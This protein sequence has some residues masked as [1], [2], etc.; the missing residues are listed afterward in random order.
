MISLTLLGRVLA[1]AAMLAGLGVAAQQLGWSL[2]RLERGASGQ[3]QT[4]STI[5]RR[6]IVYRL[7]PARWTTF[8]F[9]QPVQ[10]ARLI[11][12]PIL[13]AG[14][15]AKGESWVYAVRAELL[16]AQGRVIAVHHVHSRTALLRTDGGRRGPY[17]FYRGSSELVA[18]SDEVR[19]ASPQPFYAI[20]MTSAELAED[21]VAV[22]V[23]LSERRPVLA[24]NAASAFQ[25]YSP[26]DKARLASPNAF[27]PE[28][29]T[30][31]EQSNIAIN[32]W[33]PVG[34]TGIDGRDYRMRIL[35][36]EEGDPDVSDEIRLDPEDGE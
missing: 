30:P 10:Q 31:A 16:D 36:E 13:A 9:T 28:L 35:F 32:Q 23:R 26:D 6:L 15:A 18:P 27:P 8:R 4:S 1:V 24:S 22:D 25:R 20:R 29:L 5:V 34:P 12:H 19:L 11:S 17:R 2:E 33:R 21:L 3:V 7:D 14:S